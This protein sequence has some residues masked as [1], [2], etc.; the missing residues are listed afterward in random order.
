MPVDTGP[1]HIA[2]ISPVART[3]ILFTL[4]KESI[5]G[6]KITPP[7]IPAIT[8]SIA[9]IKLSKKKASKIIMVFEPDMSPGAVGCD[10]IDKAPRQPYDITAID[11]ITMISMY[12]V[13]NRRRFTIPT[14]NTFPW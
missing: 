1:E 9:I 11:T 10:V 2:T 7:P 13:F 14:S 6:V 8:D 5:I 3:I 12:G 4:V